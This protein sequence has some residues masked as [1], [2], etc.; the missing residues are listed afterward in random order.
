MLQKL[1]FLLWFGKFQ[2]DTLKRSFENLND[3]NELATSAGLI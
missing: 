3:A 2:L 1:L